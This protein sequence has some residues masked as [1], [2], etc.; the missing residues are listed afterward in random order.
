MEAKM[1]CKW[2]SVCP[3]RRYER[4]GRIGPVWAEKYCKPD[5]GWMECERYKLEERGIYHPD[6]MLP[7][8]TMD[9]T[10]G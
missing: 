10:L 2:Y 9:E 3:L 7:D 5:D 4:E 6:F 1:V 8:G